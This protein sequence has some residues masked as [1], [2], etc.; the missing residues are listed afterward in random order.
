MVATT[1]KWLTTFTGSTQLKWPSLAWSRVSLYFLASP[2]IYQSIFTT[3]K[4]WKSKQHFTKKLKERKQEERK[5][6]IT[7]HVTSSAPYNTQLSFTPEILG[8]QKMQP[9]KRRL[10]QKK[11]QINKMEW[12][13][14][15]YMQ[16]WNGWFKRDNFTHTFPSA[17]LAWAQYFVTIFF[18]VA[19][20]TM[21][22]SRYRTLLL[23]YR[24][25]IF[26]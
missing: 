11:N 17:D 2:A 24:F 25:S 13:K 10:K 3:F 26:T 7:N 16:I 5:L 20:E 19:L 12:V 22:E 1:I 8:K 15:S 18:F 14:G 23:V 9:R 21:L 6:R 4:P